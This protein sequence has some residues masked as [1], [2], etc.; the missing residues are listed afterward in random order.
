MLFLST[1]SQKKTI[2]NNVIQALVVLSIQFAFSDN[3]VIKSKIT[4]AYVPLDST[5]QL[6]VTLAIDEL[7]LSKEFVFI[8]NKRRR[9]IL[10]PI[11]PSKSVNIE[12]GLDVEV[13]RQIVELWQPRGYGSQKLYQFVAALSLGI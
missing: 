11:I 3:F 4:V 12:R 6:R 7:K 8:L 9:K 10:P 1:P 13:P 2:V 5:Q